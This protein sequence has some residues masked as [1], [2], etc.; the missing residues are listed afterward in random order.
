MC[1]WGF[2][3]MY[4]FCFSVGCVCVCFRCAVY[5]CG[6]CVMCGICVVYM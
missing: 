5:I 4:M 3:P 1:G 6:L 2:L